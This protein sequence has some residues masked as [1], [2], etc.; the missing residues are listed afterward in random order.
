MLTLPLLPELTNSGQ[1]AAQRIVIGAAVIGEEAGPP[2]PHRFLQGVG[3]ELH[4]RIEA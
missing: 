4:Q 2:D 1:L 3:Q